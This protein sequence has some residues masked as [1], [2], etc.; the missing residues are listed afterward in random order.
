MSDVSVS[1]R[2]VQLVQSSHHGMTQRMIAD[3]MFPHDPGR[4]VSALCC[5]LVRRGYLRT[6]SRPSLEHGRPVAWY[7][8]T[9]KPHQPRPG[10]AELSEPIRAVLE[11]HGPLSAPDIA[12]R[13]GRPRRSVY[14]ALGRMRDAGEV[15]SVRVGSTTRWTL[16]EDEDDGWVPRP[17]ISSIRARSL[18]LPLGR[19]A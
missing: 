11:A 18:G 10:W 4:E 16:V 19:A 14:E 6:E 12:Y 17:F 7:F 13:A 15:E 5:S 9:D 8:V 3:R 2:I 1:H